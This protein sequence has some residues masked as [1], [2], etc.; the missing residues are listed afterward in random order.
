MYIWCENGNMEALDIIFRPDR[1]QSISMGIPCIYFFFTS[2]NFILKFW[3]KT[4][5]YKME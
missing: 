4:I 3:K 5:V 1:R 2:E